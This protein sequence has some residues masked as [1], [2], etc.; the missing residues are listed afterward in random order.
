MAWCRLEK[1]GDMENPSMM[2]ARS[3]K[4]IAVAASIVLAVAIAAECEEAA[5]PPRKDRTAEKEQVE[6]D[7]GRAEAVAAAVMPER[8]AYRKISRRELQEMLRRSDVVLIDVNDPKRYKA[9]HIEGAVNIEYDGIAKAAK[10]NRLPR[11]RNAM[12][13]FY[14]LNAHCPA[15]RYAAIEAMRLNYRNVFVYTEGIEGWERWQGM[16]TPAPSSG[17]AVGAERASP[18]DKKSGE[19]AAK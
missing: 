13:V 18:P 5:A 19:S 8:A 7:A 12:L 11:D 17:P 4:G 1:K 6:Q 14:C 15:S 16:M 10:E 9:S 3:A 2:S